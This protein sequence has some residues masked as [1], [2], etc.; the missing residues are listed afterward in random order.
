MSQSRRQRLVTELE[1]GPA[2]VRDLSELLGLRV[3]VVRDDLAHIQRSLQDRKLQIEPAE[4]LGC[5][6]PCGACI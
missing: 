6:F 5:G 1:A 2:T 4:C 3:A